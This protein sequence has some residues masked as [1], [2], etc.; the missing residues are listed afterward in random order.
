[1]DTRLFSANQTMFICKVIWW[2]KSKRILKN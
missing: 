2:E 1:M